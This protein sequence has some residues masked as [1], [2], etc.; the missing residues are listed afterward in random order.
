MSS[1]SQPFSQ[2]GIFTSACLIE[3]YE[4]MGMRKCS[5]E[6]RTEGRTILLSALFLAAF[7]LLGWA[8]FT[9]GSASFPVLCRAAAR[10]DEFLGQTRDGIPLHQAVG[11]F[12]HEVF[13]VAE[14]DIF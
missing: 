1:V 2:C 3:L 14:A 5:P 12:L 13:C 4:V 8:Y 6:G 11:N 9:D 7:L 10:M